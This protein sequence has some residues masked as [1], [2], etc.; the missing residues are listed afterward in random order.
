MKHNVSI[1]T[2]VVNVVEGVVVNLS[3]QAAHE[4]PFMDTLKKNISKSQE[5]GISDPSGRN[6]KEK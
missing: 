3:F 2:V 6:L 1:F 4:D 5:S